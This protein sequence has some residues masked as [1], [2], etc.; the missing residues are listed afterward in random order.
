MIFHNPKEESNCRCLLTTVRCGKVVKFFNT[1]RNNSKNISIEFSSGATNGGF[2]FLKQKQQQLYSQTTAKNVR[3]KMKEYVIHMETTVK[4]LGMI[5]DQRLTWN[6]HN[7]YI[8]Q[9]CNNRMNF[10][11][12]MTGTG[13]RAEKQ[14]MVML[15]RT[16]IRLVFDYGS[17][18]SIRH[19]KSSENFL[20][21]ILAKSL[22]ICC[23]APSMTPVAAFKIDCRQTPFE[24]RRQEQLLQ[25]AAKLEARKH[26]P[27]KSNIQDCWQNHE[28][29]PTGKEPFATKTNDLHRIHGLTKIALENEYSNTLF[30][31]QTEISVDSMLAATTTTISDAEL[32]K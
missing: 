3:L 23:G 15:C 1:T 19:C 17:I 32:L 16:P 31:E 26:N 7:K 30:W 6:D 21:I 29:Y 9:R 8:V 24:P 2:I 25:Y 13:W 5:F 11:R 28:N 10:L 12:S 20:N 18:Y 14:K 4:F 27:T 22:R